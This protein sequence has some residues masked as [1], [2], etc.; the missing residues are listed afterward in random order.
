MKMNNKLMGGELYLSHAISH[1]DVSRLSLT[2]NPKIGI[3]MMNGP[4]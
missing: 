3:L 4:S 1:R 2:L